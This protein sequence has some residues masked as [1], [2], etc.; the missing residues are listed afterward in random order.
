MNE[1]RRDYILE[2]IKWLEKDLAIEDD[3]VDRDD[4]EEELGWLY[5]QL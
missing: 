2:E 3:P 4:L 5:G 1:L